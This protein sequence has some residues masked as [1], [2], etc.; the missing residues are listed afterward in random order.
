MTKVEK[1]ETEVEEPEESNENDDSINKEDAP[2]GTKSAVS[3]AAGGIAA[4][5][6]KQFVKKSISIKIKTN[7]SGAETSLNTSNSSSQ[8]TE[9]QK[10]QNAIS[11]KLKQSAKK[12][13]DVPVP[14]AAT[15]ATSTEAEIASENLKSQTAKVPEVSPAE[16]LRLQYSQYTSNAGL[17]PTGHT[18]PPPNAA[19]TALLPPP[20]LPPGYITGPPSS[21]AY[22]PPSLSGPRMMNVNVPPP[23]MMNVRPG[24]ELLHHPHAYPH[25]HLQPPPQHMHP[26]MMANN[27][28]AMPPHMMQYPPGHPA[29]LHPM[30]Q[31]NPNVSPG[32]ALM[33]GYNPM[34]APPKMNKPYYGEEDDQ[35]NINDD[36][37]YDLD[38]DGPGAEPD[39]NYDY[40]YDFEMENINDLIRDDP[41]RGKKSSKS[42]KHKSRQK[43]R[44][45]DSDED[46]PES[47]MAG[48]DLV[49][50]KEMLKNVIQMHINN[51]DE[52]DEDLK[53]M[54]DNLLEQIINDDG[55]LTH[56]DCV[57]IHNTVKNLF[58]GADDEQEDVIKKQ[59]KRKKH[60]THLNRSDSFS[61]DQ[62]M[63]RKKRKTGQDK[64]KKSH[65]KK[66]RSQTGDKDTGGDHQINTEVEAG[67]IDDV[68]DDDE[69]IVEKEFQDLLYNN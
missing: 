2:G 14:A 15:S 65:H 1:V 64:R 26:N 43:S 36:A 6:F 67:E 56:D 60:H 31:Q 24:G 13:A 69:F 19:A 42:R 48:E 25:T 28:H 34:L 22:P 49:S 27:P 46:E 3:S 10:Q 68:Y 40:N 33:P 38:D 66:S 47:D 5:G 39:N 61:D 17:L 4:A 16:K 12:Q 18:A 41:K 7:E 32:G 11:N 37:A 53:S 44:R 52:G 21:F 58:E 62:S 51:I 63:D 30:Y 8:L 50:I 20:V 54:L 23:N 45:H 35:L 9:L 59:K 29:A 55:S 57:N